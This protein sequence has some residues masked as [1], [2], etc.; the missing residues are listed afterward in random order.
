MPGT[1]EVHHRPLA[2]ASALAAAH[3][4]LLRR[5]HTAGRAG[6]WQEAV[7]LSALADVADHVKRIG[8]NPDSAHYRA[9]KAGALLTVA[10]RLHRDALLAYGDWPEDDASEQ[11]MDEASRLLDDA[12]KHAQ[13]TMWKAMRTAR[14]KIRRLP[15]RT[16]TDRHP[17]GTSYRS[18]TP[19]ALT[20]EAPASGLPTAQAAVA[21][22]GPSGDAQPSGAGGPRKAARGGPGPGGAG[23]AW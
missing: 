21:A 2:G 4:D 17:A 23:R 3:D 19:D 14:G 7:I 20:G 15:S 5:C 1:T 10:I 9:E 16:S 22:G 6:D 13:Q 12:A 18:H 8:D 11:A